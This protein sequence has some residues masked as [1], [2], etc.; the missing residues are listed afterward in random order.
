V[1]LPDVPRS[2]IENITFTPDGQRIHVLCKSDGALRTYDVTSGALVRTQSVLHV[3][4]G[5][6][7]V[8]STFELEL[9]DEPVGVRLWDWARDTNVV[10]EG[11]ERVGPTALSRNRIHLAMGTE[12]WICTFN[13]AT[14]DLRGRVR[15]HRDETTNFDVANDG[16]VVTWGRGEHADAEPWVARGGA[17][18]APVRFTGDFPRDAEL[19]PDG[20]FLVARWWGTEPFVVEVDNG[21][22]VPFNGAPEFATAVAV[23]PRDRWLAIGR[24]DSSVAVFDLESGTHSVV[25]TGHDGVVTAIAFSPDVTRLATGGRDATVLIAPLP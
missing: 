23:S 18:R 21:R 11:A 22:R 19:S 6:R 16:T 13:V 25:A 4:L 7:R 9:D 8:L 17:P 14:G 10:L 12:K 5:R 24:T 20:R 3:P 15:R 2:D 1:L